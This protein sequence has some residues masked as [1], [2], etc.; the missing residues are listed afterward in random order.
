MHETKPTLR[1]T[2]LR[3][4]LV[5]YALGSVAV[6]IPLL[7]DLA[8]DLSSTTSGKILAAALLAM[9]A[10]AALAVRDPWERRGVIQVLIAF[11]SLA[12]VAILYRL[13]FE[14]HAAFPTLTL[15]VVDVVAAALLTAFYPR[16][17]QG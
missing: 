11:L 8:G 17:S 5:V 6:V 12:A 16:P 13:L 10:G 2:I 4:L 14:G 15:L 9:G 7:L 1:T 3:A